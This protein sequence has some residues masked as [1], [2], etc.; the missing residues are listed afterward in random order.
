L[1][2]H[3]LKLKLLISAQIF[4]RFS[5]NL[6]ELGAAVLLVRRA[7]PVSKKIPIDGL[8]RLP[9]LPAGADVSGWLS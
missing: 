7:F 6:S 8:T 9:L 2:E 4:L 1:I 5:L 3:E